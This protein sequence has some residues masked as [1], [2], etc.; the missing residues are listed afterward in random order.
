MRRRE[1]RELRGIFPAVTL[2]AAVL[3]A[4]QWI[5]LL[6]RHR[7]RGAVLTGDA[8]RLGSTCAEDRLVRRVAHRPTPRGERRGED[9]CAIVLRRYLAGEI[10]RR[11]CV[12][13]WQEMGV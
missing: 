8:V 4:G 6:W 11:T 7:N 12:R 1:Y 3:A 10:D 13:L 2:V 5:A 9:L